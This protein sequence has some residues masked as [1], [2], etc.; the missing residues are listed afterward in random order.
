MVSM[1]LY[2]L[3]IRILSSKDNNVVN[4]ICGSHGRAT[5]WF[6]A[7][8]WEVNYGQNNKEKEK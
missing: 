4:L 5:D 7:S 3:H 1:T 8:V 2:S 6:A